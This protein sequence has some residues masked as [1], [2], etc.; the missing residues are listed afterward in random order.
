M[1]QG[2]LRHA[3]VGGLRSMNVD[4][5]VFCLLFLYPEA[6]S[7]DQPSIYLSRR[8]KPPENHTQAGQRTIPL[9]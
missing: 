5:D 2:T 3:P 4:V 1:V 7:G 9:W 6:A 8:G